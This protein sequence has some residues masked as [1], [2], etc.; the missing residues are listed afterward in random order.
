MH[1]LYFLEDGKIFEI[2]E[3]HVVNQGNREQVKEMAGIARGCLNLKGVDR[4]MMKEC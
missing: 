2:V 3:S 1:F 4:P